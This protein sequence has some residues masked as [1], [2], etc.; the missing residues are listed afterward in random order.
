MLGFT[1]TQLVEV[2]NTLGVQ[3]GDGLLVHSALPLLGSPEDGIETYLAALQE[4]LGA[5][6]TIAVPTFNFAFGRGQD[7]HP[8][9]TPAEGMG[10]F[11]EFVR[12]LPASQR[13]SHPMQSLAVLGKA[14]ADLADCDTPSAFDD[15]SAFDL[16]LQRGFK[17]LLLGADIQAVPLIHY[18][19]QRVGVPY[20]YWKDFTGRILSGDT[21]QEIT[22]RMYVRDMEIDARME[23]YPIQELM[24]SRGQWRAEELNYGQVSLF[25]MA[26]FV[27][28]A[29]HFLTQDPWFFV[30]N[31]PE[32]QA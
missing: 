4:A 20:R 2:L 14:A 10:A 12:Q 24:E 28:S 22:C 32:T 5:E 13:T 27:S 16:M 7:Y 8:A 23:I 26:D 31:R 15:G 6:G 25:S 18:V 21:W 30:T 19:E 29:E 11:S 17:V 1:R 9:K 3:P